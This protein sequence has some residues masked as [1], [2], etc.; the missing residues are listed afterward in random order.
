MKE[1]TDKGIRDMSKQIISLFLTF[2]LVFLWPIN[3]VAQETSSDSPKVTEVKQGNPAPFD[4][5]LF[6]LPAAAQLLANKKFVDLECS[7]KID[8]ELDKLKAKHDLM[9]KS[10]QVS[11]EASDKKYDSIIAIKDDEIGR[12]NDIALE[13]S[14][15]HSEWWAAGGFIVGALVS[16]GIF[17][18]AS[19]ISK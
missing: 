12:L 19:E 2:L 18:A 3:L 7:L 17:F 6:S 14:N 16:L 5:V 11:L 9:L 8:L 13:G 15:D 4:G 10:L 1:R